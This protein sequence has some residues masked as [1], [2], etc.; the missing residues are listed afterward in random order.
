MDYFNPNYSRKEHLKIEGLRKI[1]AIKVN[2]NLGLS[3]E[4]KLAFPDVIAVA[5]SIV[6]LPKKDLDGY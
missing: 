4:L 1:V 3:N 2:M 5:R 6:E